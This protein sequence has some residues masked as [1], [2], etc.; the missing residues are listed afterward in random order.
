MEHESNIPDTTPPVDVGVHY[1]VDSYVAGARTL[2]LS[3]QDADHPMDTRPDY[4]PTLYY[5]IN[6]GG[7]QSA[8][9]DLVSSTCNAKAVTCTFAATT[10]E[11]ET[12]DQVVYWWEFQDAATPTLLKP[13]QQPNVAQT[14][15]KS[16]TILD[17][18]DAPEDLSLIHI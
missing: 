10:A 13:N 6:G 7:Q 12:G 17:P 14:G 9:S 16:F 3:A 2:L 4:L 1:E 8:S 5:T 15:F 18:N 11:L